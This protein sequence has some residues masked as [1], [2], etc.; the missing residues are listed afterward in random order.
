MRKIDTIAI[1]CTDSPD[2]AFNIGVKDVR[3]WHTDPAPKGRG[4]SDVGY[5]Y[6]VRRDGEIVQMVPDDR[7]CYHAGN[8]NSRSIGIEH[9]A[10]INPWAVR[11]L[12]DGSVKPPPYP[13]GE[14]P[15]A[16]L[17]ASAVVS[18]VLCRKFRIPV[19]R[20]HIIGHAEVPGASHTDPGAAFPWERYIELVRVA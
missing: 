2:T 14:F 20:A 13:V 9:E 3:K 4:W 1:H 12:A 6:L 19:D 16:M 8:A 15:E 17:R 10:R 7:K 5:H 11:K 18:A